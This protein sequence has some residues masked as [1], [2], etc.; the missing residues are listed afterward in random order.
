MSHPFSPT[1]LTIANVRAFSLKI[2]HICLFNGI[3]HPAAKNSQSS[4]CCCV[5]LE[6]LGMS[7]GDKVIS[8]SVSILTSPLWP[9]PF[10][11]DTA[12]LGVRPNWQEAIHFKDKH[13]HTHRST[14]VG[15]KAEI[16]HEVG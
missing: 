1:S 5:V 12:A 3:P 2:N 14:A 7:G 11:V 4:S 6:Q 13:I 8:R 9:F 15:L 10:S 16:C